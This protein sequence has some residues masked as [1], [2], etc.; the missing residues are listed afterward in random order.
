MWLGD[1][2]TGAGSLKSMKNWS[3]NIISEGG[4]F[5]YYVNK[6]TSWL[7]ANHEALLETLVIVKLILQRKE[8][9]I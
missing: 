3:T 1:Y 6:T 8:K 9:G 2:A 7:I 4:H 5:G